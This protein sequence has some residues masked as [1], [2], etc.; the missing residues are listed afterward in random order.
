LAFGLD[1]PLAAWSTN[2]L[3][4]ESTTDNQHGTLRVAIAGGGT[5]GHISPA[6]AIIDELRSRG[7]V[8]F[9]WIG[10]TDGF[11]G[12]VA[13]GLS[14]P[15]HS[16]RTGK[17]RRYLSIETVF[18]TVR[19]PTGIAQARRQL[20]AF[21]PD[22]IFSTGGF[23]S[24]PSIISGRTL[25][26]PSLT[27]EQ[28]AYIGL[29]TR[30]NARFA[31]TVALSFER[32]RQHL[33]T[34]RA[35]VIVTGNPV[36]R[37]VLGGDPERGRAHY[38]FCADLPLVY[39][40]GGAQGSRAINAVVRDALPELLVNTQVLH[41]CGP[42]SL[43]DDFDQLSSRAAKLP[44]GL[45]QRYAVVERVGPEIGD[46]YAATSLVVGR[47]GAGTVNELRALELP[48]L[49]IPLPGAEEQR[50]N[51]LVLAEVGQAEL[52]SQDNLTPATLN[53]S[54]VRLLSSN[55]HLT[56]TFQPREFDPAIPARM[57]ADEL[58]RLGRKQS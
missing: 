9:V 15:F 54:V 50:Q 10:S 46:V 2:A 26:V 48:A 17:L 47:A 27:H 13:T 22:V 5:G 28:T 49:M 1:S 32:S 57:L 4:I 34:T 19:V 12:S 20:A 36:R 23:V 41:Q 11:E 16:V 43:H 40:T 52:L 39:V 58:I 7:D 42:R 25:G 6:V 18:D 44:D 30:I 8:E 38:G 31:N 33:G 35:R 56:R 29:A 24:V 14:I 55:G 53:E 51:A 3:A 45:R 37:T 21:R